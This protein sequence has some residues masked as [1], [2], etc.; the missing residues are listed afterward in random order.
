MRLLTKTTLY[1]F[2]AMTILLLIA[3]FYL[4]N[5]FTRELNSKSDQEL[6]Y[7]ERAW[8]KYLHTEVAR[9]VTFI[10]RSPDVSIY[11]VNIPGNEFPTIEDVRGPEKITYR[12][13]TQVV[14]V[15]GNSY[16]IVLRK[17]QEQKVALISFITKM[18]DFG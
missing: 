8:I 16:Q 9:G 4:F 10:L 13:L 15:Y 6:L 3:G 11:P 5:R 17:S 14:S 12:Q 2:T 18:I 1:F 7:E